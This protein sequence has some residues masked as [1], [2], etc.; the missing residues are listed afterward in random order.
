MLLISNFA[1]T[2][3]VGFV[4]CTVPK[5][6]ATQFGEDDIMAR[7]ARATSGEQVTPTRVCFGETLGAARMAWALVDLMPGESIAVDLD[8]AVADLAHTDRPLPESTLRDPMGQFGVTVNG[9][10]L[11]LVPN[12]A[13]QHITKD[14]PAIRGH[15]RGRVSALVV[16]DL[17]IAWVPGEPWARFEV[18]YTAANPNMPMT[19]E[20]FPH[21][22]ELKIGDAIVGYM[23]QR[24]N[25]LMVGDSLAHGQAVAFAGACVW[26]RLASNDELVMSSALLHGAPFG[27]DQRWEKEIGGMGVAEKGGQFRIRDWVTQHFGKA[28]QDL[29]RWNPQSMLGV[30]ANSGVTGDQEEQGFGANA[31]EAFGMDPLAPIAAITRYAVALGYARRPCHWREADGSL[32]SWNRTEPRLVM[33]D[34]APHWH[35][36]VSPDRLGLSALPNQFEKHGWHGPDREHWFYGGLFAAAMLT[37]SRALQLELEAQARIVWYQETVT[38]GWSTSNAGASRGVGWFGLLATGLMHCL[39]DRDTA[40]RVRQRAI[41]RLRM[42]YVPQLTRTGDNPVVWDARAD[43]RLLADLDLHYEDIRLEDGTLIPSATELPAGAVTWR[44]VFHWQKAWMPYQQAVGAFG[45]QVMGE[46]LDLPEAKALAKAAALSV[47]DCAYDEHPEQGYREWAVLAYPTDGRK[48]LP[49]EG[50]PR[51]Y[52]GWFRHAWL[53]MAVW[54][55]LRHEPEHAKARAIWQRLRA[56]I[57]NGTRTLDW[58]PPLDRAVAPLP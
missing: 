34:G 8:G 23:G 58:L 3:F 20:T 10:P 36:G 44:T 29:H 31:A 39:A 2:R 11:A 27:V 54:T 43:N 4:P 37:G 16:A 48:L 22:L 33:W 57:E 46:A 45:L 24:F 41:D 56:E 35:A 25:A 13:G 30:A 12:R 17:F 5:R 9:L 14:G 42:V 51:N 32:L 53:P 52:I 6:L 21:G 7:T 55:V 49:G 26:P 18:V 47:V 40:D 15:F 19:S 50:R 38:A 1:L 28:M